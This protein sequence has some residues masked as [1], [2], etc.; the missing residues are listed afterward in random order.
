MLIETPF[1]LKLTSTLTVTGFSTTKNFGGQ[2]RI[3]YVQ[4]WHYRTVLLPS[5]TDPTGRATYEP[6]QWGVRGICFR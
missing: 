5:S 4:G 1:T 2:D 6:G 3:S